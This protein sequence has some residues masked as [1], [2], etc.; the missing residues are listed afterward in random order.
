[1]TV[2]HSSILNGE[3]L[4]L[5]LQLLHDEAVFNLLMSLE[6]HEGFEQTM[7]QC[8]QVHIIREIC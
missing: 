8:I 1:M 3:S 6:F 2:A 7:Q 5:I 4:Q